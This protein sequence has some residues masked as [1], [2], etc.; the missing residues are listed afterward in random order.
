MIQLLDW[1][2][3]IASL[4]DCRD[5][6]SARWGWDPNLCCLD[7]ALFPQDIT[8]A[9]WLAESIARDFAEPFYDGYF[10]VSP[11]DEAEIAVSTIGEEEEPC[12]WSPPVWVKGRKAGIWERCHMS[13]D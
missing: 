12:M 11:Q 4:L 1:G 13:D 6:E 8:F 7:H 5:P 10:E 2:C 3:A 9:S